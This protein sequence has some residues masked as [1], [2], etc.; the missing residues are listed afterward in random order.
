MAQFCANSLVLSPKAQDG[1]LRIGRHGKDMRPSCFVVRNSG[2]RP[3]EH[4]RY[5]RYP[6]ASASTTIGVRSSIV[7]APNL[8]C[9]VISEEIFENFAP[10][11]PEKEPRDGTQKKVKK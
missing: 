3:C 6:W 1:S 2:C 11:F 4:P 7:V 8:R 10:P 5:G 9:S